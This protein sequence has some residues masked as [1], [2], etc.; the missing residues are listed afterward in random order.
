MKKQMTYANA[1][2]IPYVVIVGSDE[3]A[4]GEVSLKNMVTGEQVKVKADELV[5]ELSK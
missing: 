2:Q 4:S 3:V 1:K 5:T